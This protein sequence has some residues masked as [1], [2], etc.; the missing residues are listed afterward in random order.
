MRASSVCL[1][2]PGLPRSAM[3][4]RME[5]SD[6][7]LS[8]VYA[9]FGACSGLRRANSDRR[10]DH[11]PADGFLRPRIVMCD[12]VEC[13]VDRGIV[14]SGLNKS[15]PQLSQGTK[16]LAWTGARQCTVDFLFWRRCGLWMERSS[17]DK[18]FGQFG[19]QLAPRSHQTLCTLGTGLWRRAEDEKAA[20]SCRY[21]GNS[22]RPNR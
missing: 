3:V 22:G 18:L 4:L 19:V 2:S 9:C 1:E 17:P 16:T 5:V 15:Q 21:S 6:T 20:G 8:T 12:P 13:P 14:Q 10:D 7:V 11:G